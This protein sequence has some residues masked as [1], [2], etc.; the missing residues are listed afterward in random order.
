LSA[1]EGRARRGP[2][3]KLFRTTSRLWYLAALSSN[4]VRAAQRSTARPH[5]QRSSRQ[6]GLPQPNAAPREEKQAT[7]DNRVR[8]SFSQA[9]RQAV[10]DALDTVCQKLPFL[11]DLSPDERRS[12]PTRAHL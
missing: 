9:D 8:A 10:L 4:G 3:T 5:R 6:R 2:S 7:P 11:I 12:L 1:R